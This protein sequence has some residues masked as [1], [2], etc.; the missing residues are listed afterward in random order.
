MSLVPFFASSLLLES[1]WDVVPSLF[2][3]YFQITET[4]KRWGI[5]ESSTGLIVAKFDATPAEV[6][7]VSCTGCFVRVAHGNLGMQEVKSLVH[8]LYIDH[9]AKFGSLH[10]M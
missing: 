6:R 7:S 1:A 5:S 4:L 9:D 8:A 3:D 10:I 2:L